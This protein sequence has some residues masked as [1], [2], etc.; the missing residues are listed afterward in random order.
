[1]LRVMEP[2]QPTSAPTASRLVGEFLADRDVPCPE[3]GYNLRGLKDPACPE[4]GLEIRLAVQRSE[5][6]DRRMRNLLLLAGAAGVGQGLYSVGAFVW[7][8]LLDGS[9]RQMPLRYQI[10]WIG[11]ALLSLAFIFI[12]GFYTRRLWRKRHE[13]IAGLLA[14]RLMTVLLGYL[15]CIF[16]LSVL[17]FLMSFF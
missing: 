15:F 7:Y 4:C 13:E 6:P 9:M 14:R 10:D 11:H 17:R 16:L 12:A 3:C 2:S 5:R 8:F 1:M